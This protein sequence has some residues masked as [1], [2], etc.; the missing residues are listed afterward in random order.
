VSYLT[1]KQLCT[2][3]AADPS[4]EQIR[5]DLTRRTIRAALKRLPSPEGFC[6]AGY[7]VR[8]DDKGAY[9]SGHCYHYELPDRSTCFHGQEVEWD[10]DT[11]ERAKIKNLIRELQILAGS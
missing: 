6:S 3:L 2:L 7:R 1:D 11:P 5:R 10:V 9:S 4:N 8:L